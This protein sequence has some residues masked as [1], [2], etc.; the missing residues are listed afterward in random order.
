MKSEELRR[1]TASEPLTLEQEYAMQHSW[2][3]DADSEERSPSP[4]SG[5]AGFRGSLQVPSL[6]HL[7]PVLGVHKNFMQSP[8]TLTPLGAGPRG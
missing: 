1:L 4:R 8:Y 3:E 2:R 5:G 7:Q 6:S